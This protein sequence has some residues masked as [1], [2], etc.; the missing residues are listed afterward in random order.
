V[1]VVDT[2]VWINHL[3]IPSKLLGQLLGLEQVL[4][5][6]FVVGEL[7]CGNLAN[8]KEIIALLHSLPAAPRADD[9]EILF[10]VE[11]HK[12]MGRGLGLVDVHL[13]ASAMIGAASLWTADSNLGLAARNLRIEFGQH[14]AAGWRR[15]APQPELER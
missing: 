13:L 9:D 15:S 10:F 5:H 14:P 12:L 1:I 8:R 3:R 2:S 4:I 6:P 7:A 11:R